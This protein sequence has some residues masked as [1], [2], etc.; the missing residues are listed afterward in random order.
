MDYGLLDDYMLLKSLKLSD[1]LAFKEL[2][3]RYWKKMYFL[4]LSKINSTEIAEDIVQNVFTDLWDRRFVHSI[5]NISAYL[6]TATKYQTINYIRSVL[7]KK[8]F[9]AN[10]S[11][12]E[13][14][15]N[16]AEMNLQVQDLNILLD[17]ALQHLP[18][19][20]QTIFRLSRFEKRSNKDISHLMDLS[21]KSVEY[22]IS[23]SLKRLRLYLKNFNF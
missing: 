16:G 8:D 13:K 5:Q 9:L 3:L 1:Q 17:K 12:Q 18:Q 11:S 2:Y 20:T 6:T 19:K 7:V 23:Q 21:E 15:H 14:E 4:A 10:S 22:H